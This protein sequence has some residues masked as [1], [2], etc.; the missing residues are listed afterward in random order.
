MK[1]S[2]P[3]MEFKEYVV[4]DK[5]ITST[6]EMMLDA[7]VEYR[8]SLVGTERSISLIDLNVLSPME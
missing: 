8:Y 4:R 3:Y 2:L 6:R 7:F 1:S 5:L